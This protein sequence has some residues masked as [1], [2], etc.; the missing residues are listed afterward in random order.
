MKKTF[1]FIS[2]S[3]SM[4]AGINASYGTSDDM[5]AM[6]RV[7]PLDVLCDTTVVKGS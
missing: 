7:S 5:P 6:A 1:L 4:I 2:L 3:L